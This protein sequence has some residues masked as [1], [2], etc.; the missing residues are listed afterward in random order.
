LQLIKK[1][2]DSI[3]LTSCQDWYDYAMIKQGKGEL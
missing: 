1:T 2:A 3:V